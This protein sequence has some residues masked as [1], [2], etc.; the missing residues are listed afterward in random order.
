[1]YKLNYI[2]FNSAYYYII[3]GIKNKVRH[4][5]STNKVIYCLC[6]NEIMAYYVYII[7]SSTY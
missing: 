7:F 4:C 6:K 3:S 1:M 2:I 5:S